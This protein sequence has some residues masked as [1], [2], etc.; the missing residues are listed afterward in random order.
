MLPDDLL[1]VSLGV[2]P[3]D[4]VLKNAQLVNVFSGEIVKTNI[5][6]HKGYIA[7]LGDYCGNREY[8]LN[9]SYVSP[10]FID[11]HIHIES[12]MMLPH[13]F[14]R[15]VIVCGTTTVVTDPHE[16][17]NVL[18]M[19]GIELMQASA[20]LGPVNVEMMIPSCVPAT[21]METSGAR[22]EASDIEALFNKGGFCGLAEV[23]NFPGVINGVP[24]VIDKLRRASGNIIDGHSPGL[25]GQ[26]LN[27]Y[28]AAGIMSDHECITVAE[29]QEKLNL[30]MYVMIREGSA[31]K[32]ME[33]L[34]PAVNELNYARFMLVTDDAHS[35]DLIHGHINLLLKKA[36]KAG[37]DPVTAVRMV[38]LNP[39][40]YFRLEQLGAVAPG[41]RADIVVLDSL[42][43]FHP[44]MVFKDGRL[45]AENGQPAEPWPEINFP[46]ITSM[47]VKLR[48]NP[49]LIRP[50]GDKVRVIGV[51]PGQIFTR[52]LILSPRLV[53]NYALSD[54]S[55][56]ILKIAV[57]ERHQGTGNVGLGF[58]QGMGL[59]RGAIASSVAHDSHNIIVIGSND[60]DMELA[61]REVI[62]YGGGMAV[63]L[64]GR[65]TAGLP[66]PVA[67]LMAEGNLCDVS[68]KLSE[69]KKAVGEL[70]CNLEAPF[71]A[72]SFLA[73]PVIPEL[74]L[75]DKGLVDVNKFGFVSLFV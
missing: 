63:A 40:T 67:G 31:A 75:T 32:N 7:G 26:E 59:K 11:G 4:L 24:E 44:L 29:A 2:K 38:T 64:E 47:N 58:V 22:V 45:V 3:A 1:S 25:T 68:L 6:I 57:I 43:N 21:E 16:I 49:F 61:V 60:A 74:K 56:D 62:A 10:G 34:L 12:S 37:I 8:D 53:D 42:N 17:T 71:M 48:E 15:A 30:G 46:V 72:M 14:G 55:R 70:G 28:I 18:G 52:S 69:L 35:E 36:V 41:Y 50:E 19:D 13:N 20:R 5:A 33:T 23:M 9:G 27:T 73:L 51:V 54:I 66:L 39:A 65:V